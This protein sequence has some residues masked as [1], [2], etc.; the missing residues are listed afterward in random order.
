MG[1]GPTYPLGRRNYR[2]VSGTRQIRSERAAQ[3]PRSALRPRPDVLDRP[4][5]HDAL[6]RDAEAFGPLA[7]ERLHVELPGGVGV[8]VD[9]EEAAEVA[10]ELDEL[11]GRVAALGAGVDLDGDVVLEAGPEDLLGVEGRRWALAA[12]ARDELPGAVG[13]HVGAGVAHGSDHARRHLERR[14]PQ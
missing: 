7:P 6:G 13:Q 8:G 1:T 9:G 3:A 11:V 10:R 4:R 14:L 2:G 12:P 5:R